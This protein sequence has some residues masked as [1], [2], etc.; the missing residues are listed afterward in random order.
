MKT[1][2]AAMFAMAFILGIGGAFAGNMHKA[3]HQPA[4]KTT[5]V[6]WK[7]N[8]T[9]AQIADGTKY[10]QVTDEPACNNLGQKRCGILAPVNTAHPTQPDL[11]AISQEDLKN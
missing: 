6:W 11:G 9:Q 5:D 7:F 2:K 4:A 10:T 1:I 8:G 3:A